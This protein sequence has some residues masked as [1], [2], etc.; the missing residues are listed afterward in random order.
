VTS[1][2]AERPSAPP[3]EAKPRQARADNEQRLRDRLLGVRPTD[4]L[5]GWLGPL[6]IAAIGG[7]LRFWHLGQPHQLVFDET[8][9]VKEGYSIWKYG[10]ERANQPKLKA[11]DQLFTRGTP[12]VFTTYGDSVV[13]PPV[14]KWMIGFGEYLFGV[15]N[16]FGWRFSSAAVGTLSILML[17]R[18]ARR[19]FSST[20]LGCIAGLLLAVDGEHFVH[21]RTGLL[22]IFVMFWALAGFGFLLIDR[23]RS[24]AKLAARVAALTAAGGGTRPS[25]YG[26]GLGL[27]PYRIA[28]GVSLGLCCGTKWSGVYFLAVFAVMSMLWDVG[29]R[30]A[31]G[32]DSW[33]RAAVLRDGIPGFLS[34][35]PVALAVYLGSWAGWFHSTNGYDR[36]WGAQHPSKDYG[37]IPDSLRSLWHYHQW[38]YQ[39][40]TTLDSFHPYRANP[41]SWLIQGRPTDFFYEAKGK[42]DPG[43]HVERCS[44]AITS[45][46]TPSIWWGATA[47][48]LVLLFMWALRRDWRA[49]AILAG[50]LGG[51]VPWF[52]FQHR[53]IF[54]FY[55]VAF[56]P[57]IVLAVTYVLGMALGPPLASRARRAWG[58][59]AVGVYLVTTVLLFFFFWPIYTAQVIPY[60][61]W[62]KR[63][64][65]PS[66]I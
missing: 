51:Y 6:I 23:D 60:A 63:M 7:G 30:R 3:P 29:A 37:W 33:G 59:S 5:W 61:Q 39:F 22:D 21:S 12:N 44:K 1:I 19:M 27:R 8:Y 36:Q 31:V 41:W 28:A 64:W 26:P 46:G 35:V 25:G 16:S 54:T 24:R 2:V 10:I 14:G 52:Q 4:R 38:M 57:W 32:V 56:V 43:C 11:P 20:L 17:A 42:G 9:Y 45:L 65:F 62:A 55:S 34:T 47:A 49:G 15:T 48:I 13:H 66:W 40:N 53:T 58:G 18:I 50:L